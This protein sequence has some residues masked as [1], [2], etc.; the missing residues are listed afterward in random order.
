MARRRNFTKDLR[1]TLVGE[2]PQNGGTDS[3]KAIAYGQCLVD[4]QHVQSRIPSAEKRR[5]AIFS[6]LAEVPIYAR[7]DGNWA[8]PD[9]GRFSAAVQPTIGSTLS[10]NQYKIALADGRIADGW[11]SQATNVPPGSVD[12]SVAKSYVGVANGYDI[13]IDPYFQ[14]MTQTPPFFGFG[15]GTGAP[16]VAVPFGTAFV[17]DPPTYGV[18]VVYND[19][20]TSQFTFAP[21]NYLVDATVSGTGLGDFVLAA[22]GNAQISTIENASVNGALANVSFLLSVHGPDS[23]VSISMDPASTSVADSTMTIAPAFT[24]SAPN[25]LGGPLIMYINGGAIAEMRPVGMAALFTPTAST[26]YVGGNLVGAY[27]SANICEQ[28][29][30][31]NVQIDQ[32][33]QLQNWE[34]LGKTPDNFDSKFQGGVY[35]WWSPED[36]LDIQ[37]LSPSDAIN[38]AYPCLI[39][40][41]QVST[42]GASPVGVFEVGRLKVWTVYEFTTRQTLW[43]TQ[44]TAGL[45]SDYE[46]VWKILANQPH[47]MHNPEHETWQDKV[48]AVLMEI[49]KAAGMAALNAAKTAAFSAL[50]IA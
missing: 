38:M 42:V 49:L 26:A 43:P 45:T 40:S 21:G 47:A 33:G 27:V 10:P 1:N 2:G 16:T 39:I 41:G 48:K 18:G 20:P 36:E 11:G 31:T 24:E 44:V 5:T 13:R 35:V 30:F 37:L 8:G 15:V 3:N 22:F 14:N 6:S 29:F 28:A 34:A 23:G 4:P 7:V 9:A 25:D 32:V 46:M 12:W 19:A 50:A 17:L